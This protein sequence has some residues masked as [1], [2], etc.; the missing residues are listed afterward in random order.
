MIR[1][2][3]AAALLLLPASASA[4]DLGLPDLV[5]DLELPT[6][7]ANV[8]DVQRKTAQKMNPPLKVLPLA[9]GLPMAIAGMSIANTAPL[10]FAD[11]MTGISPTMA[12]AGLSLMG[13][14]LGT[15]ILFNGLARTARLFGGG[16]WQK[17]IGFFAGGIGAASA[18]L[19]LISIGTSHSL[20]FPDG[21]RLIE[22]PGPVAGIL[23]GGSVAWTVGSLFL[24]V[25][26]FKTAMDNDALLAAAP[27]RSG[28]TFAGVWVGPSVGRDGADG[29]SGGVAFVW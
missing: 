11:G 26:A 1:F 29:A 14:S 7:R 12:S 18:G 10:A 17:D 9:A 20:P 23:V 15:N 4:N 13:A 27:P 21:S 24:I 22:N 28:P 5:P 6:E 19:A 2:V 16:E 3:L 8:K 25:D